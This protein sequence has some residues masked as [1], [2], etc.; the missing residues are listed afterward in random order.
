MIALFEALA[1]HQGRY[2]VLA[3][4]HHLQGRHQGFS[5]RGFRDE[6]RG[7]ETQRRGDGAVVGTAGN[8]HDRD[9]GEGLAD[10]SHAGGAAHAGHFKV[11]KEQSDRGLAVGV[12]QDFLKGR[13]LKHLDR[14]SEAF[15]VR[16]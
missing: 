14:V 8:N 15:Q 9:A 3:R 4:Q 2:V 10:I 6:T 5:T 1:Q 7:A 12:V 16:L 11:Q 13:R